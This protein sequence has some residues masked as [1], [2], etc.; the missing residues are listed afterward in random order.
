MERDFMGKDGQTPPD[1]DDVFLDTVTTRYVELYEKVTGQTF[2]RDP[3]PDPHARVQAAVE[4]WLAE[5]GA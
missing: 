2:K 3:H 4:S 1:M 5:Q